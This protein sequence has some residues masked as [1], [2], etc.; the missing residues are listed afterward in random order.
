MGIHRLSNDLIGWTVKDGVARIKGDST[1]WGKPR[2]MDGSWIVGLHHT[3]GGTITTTLRA[4]QPGSTYL[5][6]WF[7]RYR[8]DYALKTVRVKV[9]GK[10]VSP[11]HDVPA[12]WAKRVVAF[13]AEKTTAVLE[14]Y[15]KEGKS[16]GAA[17]LDAVTVTLAGFNAVSGKGCSSYIHMDDERIYGHKGSQYNL[18]QC[19]EAVK[20]LDGKEGCKG[21]YFNFESTGY[22]NCPKDDCAGPANS[23]AG[24][25]DGQLYEFTTSVDVNAIMNRFTEPKKGKSPGGPNLKGNHRIVNVPSIDFCMQKCLNYEY[26]KEKCLAIIYWPETRQE[27][28]KTCYLL[29]RTYDGEF[30]A[31]DD[32]ALVANRKFGT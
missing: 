1:A 10:V 4:L 5:L 22:C 30:E 28:K 3:H 11:E 8:E 18:Q 14:F 32:G 23:E 19:A 29:G 31:S 6:S 2:A 13:K 7:E 15:T 16:D 24:D 25:T 27:Q 9:A 26:K 17:F 12:Q 21:K 20:K